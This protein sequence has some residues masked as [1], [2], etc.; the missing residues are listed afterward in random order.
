[1]QNW[2][3]NFV[4]GPCK[5]FLLMCLWEGLL[6]GRINMNKGA[7]LEMYAWIQR[8]AKTKEDS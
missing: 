6:N 4:S 7:G 5:R 8:R 2:V 1:M 3:K